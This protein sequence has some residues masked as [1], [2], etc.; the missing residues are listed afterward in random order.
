MKRDPKE[1]MKTKYYKDIH[2][3]KIIPLFFWERCNKCG[4]EFRREPMY[5]INYPI[6]MRGWYDREYI[7]VYGCQECFSD[8]DNFKRY[9]AENIVLKEEIL[10]AKINKILH[11]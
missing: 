6:M 3:K 2:Y 1:Y 5:K 10:K 7:S 9:C 8:I 4:K 11:C